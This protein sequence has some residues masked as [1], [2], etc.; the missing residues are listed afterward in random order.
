MRAVSFPA[1]G[2]GLK[3]GQ[4]W[5][6]SILTILT[7]SWYSSETIHLWAYSFKPTL[8][9]GFP[10]SVGTLT[11]LPD[12]AGVGSDIS[13][14][15]GIVWI[16]FCFCLFP[17]SSLFPSYVNDVLA[18]S[19]LLLFFVHVQSQIIVPYLEH[20]LRFVSNWSGIGENAT[21]QTV[22]R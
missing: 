5:I 19:Q 11:P 2:S 20:N 14:P 6:W 7:I 3:P 18:F 12:Q 13:V 8:G 15:H 16:V 10:R 17:I 4:N 1:A 21:T 22:S 9:S